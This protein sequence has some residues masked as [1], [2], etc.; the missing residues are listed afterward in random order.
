M[1][2]VLLLSGLKRPFCVFSCRKW[3]Q[4]PFF[5]LFQLS[6]HQFE[7]LA[8]DVYDEVD[9][10]ETDAGGTLT[11]VC[12]I[13]LLIWIISL[14]GTLLPSVVGHAEPQHAGDGHHS[15]ALSA[16][17]S[18]VLVH[19]KPGKSRH[20]ESHCT[21]SGS[22]WEPNVNVS[23]VCIIQG[24]QK[25]ARFSANEFATLVIDILND[26]KRRQWG[27]SCESPKGTASQPFYLLS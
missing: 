5:V 7:E 6:N 2:L 14:C 4:E 21:T 23:C 26:A 24:R 3:F 10:R 12:S 22:L 1:R 15:C 13:P 25:L 9:R 27:N 8:M 16:C 18:G 11:S 17:Q 19:Q 20:Q